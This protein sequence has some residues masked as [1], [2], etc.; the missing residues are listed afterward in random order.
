MPNRPK[1]AYV[2][3]AVTSSLAKLPPCARKKTKPDPKERQLERA[4]DTKAQTGIMYEQ[5][6]NAP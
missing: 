6:S 3:I 4:K 2:A 5:P 1:L